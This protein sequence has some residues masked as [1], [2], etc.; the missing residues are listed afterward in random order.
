ML[1]KARRS[2]GLEGNLHRFYE[3]GTLT[4][5]STGCHLF[6]PADLLQ[7]DTQ[8]TEHLL[9]ILASLLRSLPGDSAER[10]RLLAKFV[11]KDYEKIDRV[12]K[13]RRESASKVAAVDQDLRRE[14]ARLSSAHQDEGDW[15]DEWL[16]RRMDAGLY[17]L[18]TADVVLAWLVA[19]DAGAKGRI[20]GLLAERDE[21]LQ[22]VRAT[23][24]GM[25]S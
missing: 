16:S 12:M 17:S 23:L 3:K 21:S 13:I 9:G 7:H 10:I 22:V 18:Q 20:Q 6:P 14:K 19:E 25:F 2:R 15:G 5:R 1:S 8:T 4:P 11:E 24:Q